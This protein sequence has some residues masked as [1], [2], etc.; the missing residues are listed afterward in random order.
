[1]LT[2]P[3]A[4]AWG[5][6]KGRRD[7]EGDLGGARLRREVTGPLITLTTQLHSHRWKV[8]AEGCPPP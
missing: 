1:M 7:G 6:Q 3:G 5:R 8:G 4:Q 2:V